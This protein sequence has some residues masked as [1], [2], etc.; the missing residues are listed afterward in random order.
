MS[1]AARA[2]FFDQPKAVWATAFAC[3]V[4]FMS[5]GLVDPILTS[6]AAGLNASPSQVSLL[7][8]SYFFVTSVMMLVTGFVSSRLGGRKT[9][10]LG[11]V[12]IVV[13]AGLAGT[14][15]S[16][17]GLVAYRAGWGLG[18]AFFVVTALS[19]IVAASRGGTAAAI[20]MYEAALGLG[21]SAGPLLGAALGSLSWRYPFFGTATL[22]A[23][24]F[25]A[26]FVLLPEQ[27][28]PKEKVSLTAPIRALGEPGLKTAA[29]S[30]MFYNYAFF[31]VLAFV[32][33]VLKMS[34]HAVGLIF[35]GWGV[36]LAIFSVL[37]APRLQARFSAVRLLSGC[38]A[39]F[40]ALLL[41][42]A[43]GPRE[44]VILS[45]VLSGALMGVCNTVYTEIALEVS[46]VPRPVASAGY[47]FVRW[48][49]GVVAPYAAPLIA[50]HFGAPASF[51][52]AALAAA[53]APAVLILR[54]RTLGRYGAGPMPAGAM[55][56]AAPAEA[57]P[58]AVLAAIDGGTTDAAILARA[59]DLAQG[60]VGRVHVLHVR[61]LEVID[62]GAVEAETKGEAT[63]IL[64][65]ALSRVEVAGGAPE[66]EILEAPATRIAETIRARARALGV[67]FL[68]AGTRHRGD[69]GDLVHGS[70]A[71]ALYRTAGE[72]PELVLVPEPSEDPAEKTAAANPSGGLAA[73][74]SQA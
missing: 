10:L 26:I 5:I 14:A 68:V 56:A 47:N 69:I 48:F 22:M 53:A 33:F 41:V 67:R 3:V 12:L 72:G 1:T 57:M 30:A 43:F 71:E 4:G 28:K 11:A 9:L 63:E 44:A 23:I 24:G 62:E 51:V 50:E 29:V 60:Q 6:I 52:L 40:S 55:P 13:F 18:N 74:V 66:A 15:N 25:V 64:A 34:A 2:R 31:T 19:V 20:L 21:I 58:V 70:V 17:A 8:T 27:P 42:I 35:F 45:V 49:A 59:V 37:V 61:P 54:S 39:I 16:V 36:L 32:P 46:T 65:R 73:T 7:F 38:L